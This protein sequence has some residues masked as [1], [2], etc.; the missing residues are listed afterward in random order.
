MALM[1]TRSRILLKCTGKLRLF[2]SN[3]IPKS[4]NIN[5]V[6]YET[7]EHWTNVTP[8][9]VSLTDRSLHVHESHPV[10]ILREMI[11]QKLNSTDKAFNIY[12]NFKPV[13]SVYDNFD[14]LGFPEDHPGRSKSDT[15]YVN[16]KHLLR[17]H[18][19]AHEMKCFKDI[20]SD[21]SSSNSGRSGF[22]ISADV[23]RRDEIDRTHY[24][25]FHQM[26]G[27]RIWK[28]EKA[29]NSNKEPQHIVQLRKDIKKLGDQ[30][31]KEETKLIVEDDKSLE[32]NPKQ[33]YMTELEVELCQQHL[34]RSVEL[35][36]SEVFNQKITSMKNSN[37]ADIPKELKVR[38]I[39]AYFPWT[40][41]S[42]EIEVWWQGDWLE[43]CGCGLVRE[44]VLL[45]S[46]FEKDSTIGWAFGLGLDRIAML[47][48][49]VPD[50][51]LFWTMDERFHTQ[52]IKGKIN[53][54]VP[55]S[56]YPGTLRDVSFWLAND[57]NAIEVHENDVMEIVRNEG[58]DLVE[59]VKLID[60]FTSS[61]SGKKS[62]CYRI[63]YQSM[64]RNVT[65]EEINE[66][67]EKVRDEL[68]NKYNVE[69]R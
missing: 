1:I 63:N 66:I 7:N 48:F 13:V 12:N 2:S 15:Y 26:E 23:Y 39:K 65:N 69:L 34:K 25:A 68:V 40:A 43:V 62:L 37:V 14:S 36:V 10:S 42:W 47:L 22:L 33:D 44:Q 31:E 30:L 41:P 29:L 38:W 5:E 8:S 6:D 21:Q 19:S 58:G 35:V 60:E 45:N 67:Q 27:A 56:K 4:I 51:R 20:K 9:I 18:T 50:I 49:E 46:G 57:D 53:P 59:S 16:D 11:E 54:F 24:P 17:T 55:Y 61:K 32:G 52:F 3:A 28:R 64:D